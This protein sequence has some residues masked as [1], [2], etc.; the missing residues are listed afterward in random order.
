MKENLESWNTN[1]VIKLF[2]IKS[3]TALLNAEKSGRIPEAQ[4]DKKNIRSWQMGDLPQIGHMYG[5]IAKPKDFAFTSIC[6]FTVKG[7]VLKTTITYVIARILALHGL[8]VLIVGNDPQSSITG[9]IMNP[10]N[11]H[12]SLDQLPLFND[13][14]HILFDDVS[15]SQAI[16]HTN[17]PT[18][19]LLP[20]TKSLSDVADTM[21]T[22]AA[23]AASKGK[24]EDAQ[25]RHKYYSDVLNPLIKEAGYDIVIYDNGPGL[26]ALSENALFASDYWIT[27]NSCD[28]G[29]YQ[30]FEENF[31][32]VLNFAQR[33]GKAW[34]RIFLVPTVLEQN[35]LSKQI[36]GTYLTKYPDFTTSTSIRRT[37]KAQEALSMG[38]SPPEVFLESEVGGDFMDLTTEIWGQIL[39]NQKGVNDGH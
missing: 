11:K 24:E 12:K 26:G 27:P 36:Y 29:S 30:V 16:Q 6:V 8:K 38:A 19:D 20:E 15:L 28:Q 2:G 4:R 14:G 1:E 34:K 23:L 31:N 7:G 13:L 25:P 9:V 39:L 10:L 22:T 21:S 17:L 18:L 5:R 32:E 33:K 3:K 37:V 35:N